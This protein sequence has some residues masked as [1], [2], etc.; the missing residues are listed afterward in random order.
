MNKIKRGHL[1]V[2]KDNTETFQSLGVILY[3]LNFEAKMK[4][5][6]K[7]TIFLAGV[8]SVFYSHFKLEVLQ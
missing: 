5:L 4:Y 7:R 1:L 2:I 3:C 8:K 6:L